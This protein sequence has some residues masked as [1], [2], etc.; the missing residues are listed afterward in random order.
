MPASQLQPLM[1]TALPND[2]Q[3]VHEVLTALPAPERQ[4]PDEEPTLPV[5]VI[6]KFW[7]DE[8]W[9]KLPPAPVVA[10][11]AKRK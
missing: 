6:V 3:L 5:G 7:F 9:P 4:A 1:R 10:S 2:S 11:T 8:V